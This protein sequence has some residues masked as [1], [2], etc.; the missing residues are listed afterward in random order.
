MNQDMSIINLVLQASTV[1]QLV[2]AGL[3]ITS[4]ASWTVIFSKLFGLRKVRADNDAFEQ[5]FWAGKNLNDLYNDAAQRG[6]ESAPM[7]RIFASGM[8]E[9]GKLRD[10]IVTESLRLEYQRQHRSIVAALKARDAAAARA[11]VV[12]H[13]TCAHRNLFEG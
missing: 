5:E 7:E 10:R 6:K 3:L 12:A 11:A 9:F 1:V 13:L 4:L 8:R 2:M